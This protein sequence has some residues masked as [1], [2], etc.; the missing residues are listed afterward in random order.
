MKYIKNS[1]YQHVNVSC[2]GVNSQVEVGEGSDELKAHFQKKKKAECKEVHTMMS[3]PVRAWQGYEVYITALHCTAM[4]LNHGF[5]AS[6]IKL[7][8]TDCG[9]WAGGRLSS[10]T[11]FPC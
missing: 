4:K 3:L 11:S 7:V 1:K 10:R 2:I 6:F 8:M 5:L 9:I